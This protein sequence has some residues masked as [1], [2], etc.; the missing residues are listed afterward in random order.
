MFSRPTPVGQETSYGRA[1]SDSQYWRDVGTLDAYWNANMDLTG[2]DPFFNLY[3]RLWPIRNP[4]APV[5]SCQIRFQPARI[6]GP[7]VRLGGGFPG[8]TGLHNKRRD[9]KEFG[10][11]LQRYGQQLGTG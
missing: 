7:Q 4:S 8:F 3:G 10:P 11:F 2:I 9:R 1:T 6:L 5:S